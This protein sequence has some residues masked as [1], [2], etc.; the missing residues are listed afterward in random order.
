MKQQEKTDL[1]LW[2]TGRHVVHDLHA[3][4][5]L[6]PKYRRQVMTPRVST[7]L[8]ESFQE[9]CLRH[10]CI[11]EAF[12]TDRDH[13]HLLLSWPPRLDLSRMVML[14]KTNSAR[15]VRAQ[16]FEEVRQALWG[17]HFWSPSYAIAST[18]GAPLEVVRQYIE[19]Q[20]APGRHAGRPSKHR[21][22]P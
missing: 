16:G 21:R 3:H 18:G 10:D 2:R 1:R 19:Q 20:Q 8:R 6:T 17:P 13:A 12:E 5:V 22:M 4:I 11:L 14:L 15:A 7:V 9:S